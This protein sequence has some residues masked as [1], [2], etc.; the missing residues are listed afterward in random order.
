MLYHQK[1]PHFPTDIEVSE[2]I[3]ECDGKILLVQR[4]D[5]CTEWWTWCGPGGKLEKWESHAEALVREIK[6][7][8]GVDISR[9][10]HEELFTKYFYFKQ[11]YIAIRFYR[12]EIS[13]KPNITLND[14]H[15]DSI[16]ISPEKALKMN[17]NED[18]DIILKEIYNL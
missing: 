14:E 7:E 5:H 6:E 18:F 4:S 15:Q 17:L 10:E 3:I 16:W 11:K 13:I 12:V 8:I 1:P 2:A 9:E